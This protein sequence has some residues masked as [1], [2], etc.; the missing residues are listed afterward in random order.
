MMPKVIGIIPAAGQA[1]RL[2]GLPVCKELLPVGF[3]NTR[4]NNSLSVCP[5]VVS[6]YLLQAMISAAASRVY[7]IL[8]KEKLD[9]LRYYGD[10][11][12]FGV[13]IAYILI[14]HL[15]GMPYTINQAHPWLND[16]TVIFGMPD[17]IF[18]PSDV[19]ARLLNRHWSAQNDLTLG[20]FPT[21]KP[22]RFGMVEVGA[23]DRV[24]RVVDK[25]AQT[26]LK[27]MWGIACWSPRF[28]RFL[29]EYLPTPD[30]SRH[31]V[32]LGDVFQAAVEDHLIVRAMRFDDGEYIDI[33]TPEDLQ[34]VVQR[35]GGSIS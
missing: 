20:L 22:Q 30:L 34:N 15:A 26:E 2:A 24:V 7:I 19:F 4:V 10:G 3:R 13:P 25:P 14:E 32:V 16:E 18:T 11:S 1:K 12:E 6:H 9:L 28:T 35:F 23:A 27:W 31:E 29:D 5:K 21:D 17:T 33:G 8:T